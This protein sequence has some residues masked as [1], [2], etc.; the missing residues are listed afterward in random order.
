MEKLK[1]GQIIKL[2]EYKGYKIIGEIKNTITKILCEKDG[3]WYQTSY[4]N[5]DCGKTPSL[6]GFNNIDNLEHN[7][8]NN[9]N[10][11]G[12]KSEFISYKIIQHKQK[13][14]ILCTFKCECGKEFNRILEDAIYSIHLC[15]SDCSKKKRGKNHRKGDKH[16]QTILDAGYKIIQDVDNPKNSEYIEVEDKDG[17]RGFVTSAHVARGKGMSRFDIRVNRK[18]YI[19]NANHYAKL[20]NIDVECLSF[21][22][23]KHTRQSLLFKCSCGNEFVTSL[24]YFQTGK[25]RCEVCAKSIS[26]YELLFKKYLDEIGVEYIYQYAL[27]QCRDVLP[28]PFDFFLSKYNCL[29]EIDG[30]GHFYPCNFNQISNEKAQ[31]TFDITKRHDEI[32]NNYCKENDIKLLRIPYTKFDDNTYKEFF[33]NFIERVANLS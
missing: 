25:A 7:I 19:Y 8:R 16:I 17:Y 11:R 2:F 6:W 1:D 20:N 32:K 10:K 30:E 13:K 4:H 33:Q 31:E 28:L 22:E 14:R 21:A 23:Q 12:V 3:Y 5:L 29:I 18:Y 9:I 27:N 24:P 15:C 26:S